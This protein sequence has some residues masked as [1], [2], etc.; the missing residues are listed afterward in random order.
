MATHDPE[1]MR[2]TFLADERERGRG[3]TWLSYV[4][5]SI[6]VG[7][8]LFLLTARGP[9]HGIPAF[10]GGAAAILLLGAAALADDRRRAVKAEEDRRHL[11]EAIAAVIIARERSHA[12]EWPDDELAAT[13]RDALDL[14]DRS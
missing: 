8:V 2:T 1:L 6:A 5:L 10:L 13:V 14:L 3:Q 9:G 12:Q 11:T 4:P 7:F